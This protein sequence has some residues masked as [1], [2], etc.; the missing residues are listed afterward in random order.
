[1]E[2]FTRKKGDPVTAEQCRLLIKS[3]WDSFALRDYA[4]ILSGLPIVED[5]TAGIACTNGSRIMIAPQGASGYTDAEILF[6]LIHEAAHCAANHSGRFAALLARLGKD[7]PLVHTLF[8]VAADYTINDALS[9]IVSRES[10]SRVACPVDALIPPVEFKGLSTE[11]I[12]QR[13]VDQ[14]RKPEPDKGDGDAQDGDKGDGDAQ[15]V[16]KVTAPKWGSVAPNAEL[17]DPVVAAELIQRAIMVER[18]YCGAGDCPVLTEML[19]AILCPAVNWKDLLREYM[20]GRGSNSNWYRPNRRN[21][22]EFILPG[23]DRESVRTYVAVDTSGSMGQ[24]DLSRIVKDLN[25]LT[26]DIPCEIT[27]VQCDTDIRYRE[28]FQRGEAIPLELEIKGG[29]GTCFYPALIDARAQNAELVIY[30]TDLCGEYSQVD[31]PGCPVLWICTEQWR[32]DQRMLFG[33][34]IYR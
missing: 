6:I 5:E 25:D 1:M 32:S 34:V 16:A 4:A 8:N 10:G 18:V 33:E 2:T 20:S 3:L 13:L 11:E 7:T 31:D 29:G 22:S 26:S 15:D 14:S 19:R 23:K 30:F 27:L 9:K 28:E 21:C 24:S 17:I 12:Y